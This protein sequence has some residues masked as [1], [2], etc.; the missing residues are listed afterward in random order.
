[1]WFLGWRYEQISISALSG[2][3]VLQGGGLESPTKP[4]GRPKKNSIPSCEQ[5]SAQERSAAKAPS[6]V[7]ASPQP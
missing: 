2:R 4:K 3:Q 1:M 6:S 5:V 7:P